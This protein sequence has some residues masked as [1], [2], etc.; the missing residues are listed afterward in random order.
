MRSDKSI[1]PPGK[2]STRLA[3]MANTAHHL[4]QPSQKKKKEKKEEKKGRPP[5]RILAKIPSSKTR[6]RSEAATRSGKLPLVSQDR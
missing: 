3:A 2:T 6:S 5:A 1:Q 4:P